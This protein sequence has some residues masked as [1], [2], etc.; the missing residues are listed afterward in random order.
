M[1]KRNVFKEVKEEIEQMI[2]EDEYIQIEINVKEMAR[3]KK[4]TENEA[5]KIA[6]SIVDIFPENTFIKETR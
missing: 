6:N 1:R 2:Q 3:Y 4:I 5:E